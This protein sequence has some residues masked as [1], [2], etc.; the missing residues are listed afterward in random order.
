MPA[1]FITGAAHGIGRACAERFVEAGWF[2]GAFDVDGVACADFA[3]RAGTGRAMH[4]VLDVTDPAQWEEAL[5]NFVQASGGRIDVLLNNAGIL[6]DGP[7]SE[8]PL[9]KQIAIMRINV[10][11][12]MLGCYQA[13]PYLQAGDRV[14]NMGSA[15]ALFGA[16]SL[17]S[18][19]ASKFAVR[20]LTEGLRAEW[21][22][23]GIHVCD[24]MPIFV[25]T[26]MVE[27]MTKVQA[28]SRFGA[29]LTPTD[30]A[31][32]V[33]QAATD[34]RPRAHYLV[35]REVPLLRLAGRLLPD[36]WILPL[37]RRISGW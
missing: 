6:A 10:E 29:R 13:K 1:I 8:I 22:R 2:V 9:Q 7:F 31:S 3:R 15:S 17:V 23:E 4:G 34:V 18:Y 26:A 11:G 21:H 5:R 37:V 27:G 20:G 28:V 24:L 33:Y 19:A 35:G 30:V 12:V 16:P 14:I 25:R 36:A 32:K